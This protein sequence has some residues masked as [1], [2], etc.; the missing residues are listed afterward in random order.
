MNILDFRIKLALRFAWKRK[1][2][3]VASVLALVIGV[4]VILFNSLIFNGVA[5]GILRD[6]SD[7]RFAHL[8]VSKNEGSFVRTDVQI[9]NY[10]RTISYVE[11]AAPRLSSIAWL[12]STEGYTQN[13]ADKVPVV[14][15]DRVRDKSVSRLFETIVQGSF[16]DS[17]GEIVLGT[18]V[19]ADLK[20]TV[21]SRIDVKMITFGGEPSTKRFVV[22]G[23][24]SSPGG[25]AFDD[26]G[27]MS[28]EDLREMIG[29]PNQTGEILIR[30]NDPSFAIDLKERLLQAYRAENLNILTVEEAGEQ[31]LTGIR[32]GIAFINLVGY[33]GMLSATFAIVTIMMLSVSSKTRDIG[34]MKALGA[35]WRDI[36]IIFVFQGFVIGC[37][38]AAVGFAVGSILA[39]YLQSSDFSFGGGLALKITYDPVFTFVTA[40]VAIPLGVAASIYPAFKASRLEPVDAMRQF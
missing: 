18:T 26:S 32:S 11:S 10:V 15:I 4:M 27:I 19:A 33:F 22:S 23:I 8:V 40:L 21:G 30:L 5:E 28:I 14:G 12:N 16:P 39:L 34:I 2:N 25:L 35:D 36:I 13:E 29:R 20:A 7:Y 24:S 1:G 38:S 9:I 6:L 3:F 31:T 37:I 17:R